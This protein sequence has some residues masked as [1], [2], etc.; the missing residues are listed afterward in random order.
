GPA[1]P[2]RLDEVEDF[3]LRLRSVLH[4][5]ARRNQNVLTHDLQ[6]RAAQLLG[7]PGHKTRQQVERLMSDYFRHARVVSRSLEWARRIAPTPAGVNLVRTRDGIRFVDLEKAATEPERWIHLFQAA[8]DTGAPVADEALGWI[9]QHAEQH[10]PEA[11]FPSGR[12]R[13]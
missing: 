6:E 12:G 3:L 8:I 1:E 9:Q 10:T 4:A 5:E 7:Y 13:A 11:F 2:A